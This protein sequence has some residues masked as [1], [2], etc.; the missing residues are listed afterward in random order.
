VRATEQIEKRSQPWSTPDR[1]SKR[2]VPRQPGT[3]AGSRTKAVFSFSGP[4]CRGKIVRFV[5]AVGGA[6]VRAGPEVFA[7]SHP[8]PTKW[9]LRD[10]FETQVHG[11]QSVQLQQHGLVLR[12]QGAGCDADGNGRESPLAGLLVQ[13][14][15]WCNE[16]S[17]GW[18]G[19]SGSRLIEGPAPTGDCP[20]AT[21]PEGCQ[22]REPVSMPVTR[23]F[24]RPVLRHTHR[25]H[26]Q[27]SPVCPHPGDSSGIKTFRGCGGSAEQF[28][29]LDSRTLDT[30][31]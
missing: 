15:R 16:G 12:P 6:D 2:L 22:S 30:S 29:S 4:A 13:T 20:I 7:G 25:L 1:R 8:V 27:P 10:P 28:G 23:S 17:R 14:T 24:G 3:G 19:S 11:Q 5:A 21:H 26:D 31:C 9:P 18:R